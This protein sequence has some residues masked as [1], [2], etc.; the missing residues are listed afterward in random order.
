MYIDLKRKIAALIEL[1]KSIES[2]SVD[3]K[4]ELFYKAAIANAWFDPKNMEIA[5]QGIAFMLQ[6]TQLQQWL[7]NYPNL[8][9]EINPKKVGVIM[10]GNIP[11]VG[12]LDAICVLLSNHILYAKL[13]KDDSI[14]M[15]WLLN[16]L[17]AIEPALGNKIVFTEQ[18]KNIDALIATG[19]DNSSRYFEHYFSKVPH[20]IRKNRTSIAILDGKE[21]EEALLNLGKDI[22]TYYG[23]GCRNVSKILI[24][25][26]YDLTLFFE[27]IFSYSYVLQNRKYANNYEYNRAIYLMNQVKFL[28][29]NFLL[30]KESDELTSPVGVLYF[31]RYKDT[32]QVLDLIN[33]NID[34]IQCI[35]VVGPQGKEIQ[36]GNTQKPNIWDYADGVDTLEFLKNI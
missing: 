2:I 22:F 14:L 9:L 11:A 28:D 10:A 23:L 30:I 31:S 4:T 8:K 25:E 12:L 16:K 36:F 20:I 5:L 26:N 27:A 24:P 13:S 33:E 1:G 35:A 17:Q 19:S 29:N 32:D 6:P 21:S 7:Q 18:L 15:Q 3:E 34:K